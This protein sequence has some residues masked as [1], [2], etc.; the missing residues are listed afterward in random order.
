MEIQFSQKTLPIPS[1]SHCNRYCALGSVP[2]SV[3][4]SLVAVRTEKTGTAPG[5]PLGFRP[6]AGGTRAMPKGRGAAGSPRV[7]LVGA[8]TAQA[9]ARIMRDE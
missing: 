3:R 7:R 9:C 8:G 5:M 6:G 4:A 2:A 1:S